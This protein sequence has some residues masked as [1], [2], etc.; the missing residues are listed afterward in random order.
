MQHTYKTT[1][2]I[3]L[4][5]A[6][7]IPAAAALAQD[8]EPKDYGISVISTDPSLT[9]ETGIINTLVADTLPQG[10]WSFGAG[11]HN[12]DRELTDFDVNQFYLSIAYGVLNDL[13]VS[14]AFVPMQQVT[15]R[16]HVL[17][18][19]FPPPVL[20]SYPFPQPTIEEGIGDVYLAAKYAFMQGADASPGLAVRAFAKIATGDEEE[21]FGSGAHD[22][23]ADLI[24]SQHVGPLLITGNLGYAYLGTPDAYDEAGLEF[25]QEIRYG[26]GGKFFINDNIRVVGEL[27]GMSPVGDD[28]FPQEDTLDA[29]FGLEYKMDN[30][31]R[32][33]AGYAR[34]V[35]FDDPGEDANGA[36]AQLSFSPWRGKAELEEARRRD[37]E[38]RNRR[39]AEAARKQAEEKAHRKRE[40]E[41]RLKAEEEARK[42]AAEE[43]RKR[44]LAEKTKEVKKEFKPVDI[45]FELDEYT[46]SDKAISDL[47]ALATHLKE[48]PMVTL[49]IEGHCCS[50]G[51]EEYNMA[52]GENRAN[53]IREYLM[54]RGIAST[55]I[56]IISF[57]ESRPAFDNSTESTR[58]F[59]RRGH[60]LLKLN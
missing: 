33:G 24:V 20:T 37:E 21:G 9:G 22:F 46:L 47:D 26:V 36:Y 7:L 16:A 27:T 50:I 57:G 43:A 54:K 34:T 4:A 19:V 28:D 59:N 38:E 55:R 31:L 11:F 14:A 58:R 51:T 6:L 41:A 25:G 56:S 5:L 15:Y 12:W 48:K 18:A 39:A 17:P 32:L 40:E 44:E 3:L 53:A 13:E 42:K 2:C 35:F 10:A 1:C 45:L 60:F 8:E 29:K 52:L 23:G 30:G 49:T